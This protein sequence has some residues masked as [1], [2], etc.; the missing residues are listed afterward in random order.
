M[1]AIASFVYFPAVALDQLRTEYDHC[2]KEKGRSDTDYNGSGY[3]FAT[4]LPYLSSS[5]LASSRIQC[6]SLPP[7]LVPETMAHRLAP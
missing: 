5:A 3:L 7:S 2:V 1:S 4:L 6:G